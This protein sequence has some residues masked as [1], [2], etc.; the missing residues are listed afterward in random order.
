MEYAGQLF[1]LHPVPFSARWFQFLTKIHCVFCY[2]YPKWN[3]YLDVTGYFLSFPASADKKKG[4]RGEWRKRRNLCLRF[5][6]KMKAVVASSALLVACQWEEE[7]K[8]TWAAS[9]TSSPRLERCCVL[10]RSSWWTLDYI[11][12][13]TPKVRG[14]TAAL[15]F[16]MPERM[17]TS[18]GRKRFQSF[19]VLEKK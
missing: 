14:N 10:L 18:L 3:K 11:F 6:W 15:L 4:R 9:L 5:C 16:L 19:P 8:A 17:K 1:C 7:A 2:Y 12:K 13:M